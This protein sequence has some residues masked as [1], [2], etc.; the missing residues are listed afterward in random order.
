MILVD[1]SLWVDHFR[2]A[3]R[4]LQ[5]LL[6]S[7]LVLIHPYIFG[8]LSLGSFRERNTILGHLNDLPKVTVAQETDIL[9]F[10]ESK[11]LFGRGIGYIDA[12]LLVSAILA[13]VPLWTK[14]KNLRQVA[15]KLEIAYTIP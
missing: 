8:E 7:G 5:S 13:S 2:V 14:D 1:A 10:I 9:N 11:N 12:H 3:N 4:S 15:E 6:E